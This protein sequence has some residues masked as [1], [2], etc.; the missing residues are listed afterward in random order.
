MAVIV[1][2]L[3][4]V[5]LSPERLAAIGKNKID[6]RRLTATIFYVSFCYLLLTFANFGS[7]F[8]EWQKLP[9]CS[10]LC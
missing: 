5:N 3:N 6:T 8:A 4:A 10:V 9:L 7:D 1:D 2:T